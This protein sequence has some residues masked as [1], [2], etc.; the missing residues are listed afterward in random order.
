MVSQSRRITIERVPLPDKTE[1]E[2]RIEFLQNELFSGEEAKAVGLELANL[3]FDKHDHYRD[4]ILRVALLLE[5]CY[6]NGVQPDQYVDLGLVVR[7]FDK[8]IRITGGERRSDS[9]SPWKD[10]G[11]YGV[12]GEVADRKKGVGIH[13]PAYRAAPLSAWERDKTADEDPNRPM[14]GKEAQEYNQRQAD[15]AQALLEVVKQMPPLPHSDRYTD[16]VSSDRPAKEEIDKMADAD[17]VKPTNIELQVTSDNSAQAAID[18]IKELTSVRPSDPIKRGPVSHTFK[19][20]EGVWVEEITH[21][22]DSALR[23][24]VRELSADE[25]RKLIKGGVIQI[26]EEKVR[27]KSIVKVITNEADA[28]ESE[29]FMFT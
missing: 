11:G 13:A 16:E 9:E 18:L 14:T 26:V 28:T 21:P 2:A 24:E 17:T 15:A 1:A 6:P 19:N 29:K 20:I 5:V 10:I 7:V 4:S 8:M 27:K 25:V 23:L 12:L 22:N 3:L